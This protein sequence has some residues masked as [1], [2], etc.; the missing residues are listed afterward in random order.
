MKD[1]TMF[2]IKEKWLC[3][4]HSIQIWIGMLGREIVIHWDITL[5]GVLFPVEFSK[6]DL[7]ESTMTHKGAIEAI[8]AEGKQFRDRD[9]RV[10]R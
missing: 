2:L 7:A 9:W 4:D 10:S 1:F 6:V 8:T 3:H 5:S